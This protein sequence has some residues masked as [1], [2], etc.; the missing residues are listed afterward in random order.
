VLPAYWT[1]ADIS[2]DNLFAKRELVQD[3]ERTFAWALQKIAQVVKA[4]FYLLLLATLTTRDSRYL[5]PLLLLAALSAIVYMISSQRSGILILALE[6][7][8]ALQL[9]GVLRA[10]YLLILAG[11]FA[12]LNIAILSAR[13]AETA[14]SLYWTDL[15]YRRYFFDLEKIAA[16]IEYFVADPLYRFE[17]FGILASGAADIDITY[18][19]H[20]FL[21]DQVF[22]IGGGV[23]PSI[24]GEMIIYAGPVWI[25]PLTLCLTAGLIACERLAQDAHRPLMQLIL[26]V[27]LSKLYFLT[28]NSDTLS[29]I[30]RIVLDLVL[31]WA[32]LA[33]YAV[34]AGIARVRAD[35]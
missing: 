14:Q 27:I 17:S 9:A 35:I 20:F 15:I 1:A 7:G 34:F 21:A 12:L 3:G 24:L 22:G 19:S 32:G 13:A 33:A 26:V 10:R 25:V 30:N 5:R 6:T 18:S 4:G 8:L 29:S 31:L 23:P 11:G 2:F 28:L 16:L